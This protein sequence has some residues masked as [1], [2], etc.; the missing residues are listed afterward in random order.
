MPDK[1]ERGEIFKIYINKILK[2]SSE[3]EIWRFIEN[4][5]NLSGK[6]IEET[7]NRSVEIATFENRKKI[8]TKDILLAINELKVK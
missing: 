2:N 4:S 6:Q 8:E 7:I 1:F 5:E 3:L